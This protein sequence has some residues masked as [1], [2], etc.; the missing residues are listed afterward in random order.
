MVHSGA[1]FTMLEPVQLSN[2]SIFS[3]CVSAWEQV[4]M[5]QSWTGHPRDWL[6][7]ARAIGP[8]VSVLTSQGPRAVGSRD[9]PTP[10]H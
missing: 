6:P 4:D 10:V 3:K 2:V 5:R 7:G 1:T 9:P 8:L